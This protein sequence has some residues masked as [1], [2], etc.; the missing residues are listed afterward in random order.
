MFLRKFVIVIIVALIISFVSFKVISSLHLLL[1][2]G[3][4]EN[5]FFKGLL[6]IGLS[7]PIAYC[8]VF[9]MYRYGGTIWSFFEWITR[10]HV[11]PPDFSCVRC[12]SVRVIIHERRE[13]NCIRRIFWCKDCG[14]EWSNIELKTEEP[15]AHE[16]APPKADFK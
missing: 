5:R 7:L 3:S 9:F 8:M 12:Q 13:D 10:P 4:I 16:S 14:Y 11:E 1:K 15:E 6:L 2:S